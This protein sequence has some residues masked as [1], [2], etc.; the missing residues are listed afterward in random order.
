MNNN[1]DWF[2]HLNCA[3]T[4]CDRNATIIYMNQKAQKTFEKWGG[5]NLLGKSLFDCHNPRSKETIERL[6]NENLSNTYTIEKNGIKKLIYQTPWY[7]NGD[8]AGLIEFSIEVPFEMP[9]FVR[10]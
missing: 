3:V 9:H 2:K 1:T 6:M 7:S 4:I 5:D 8:V 10:N